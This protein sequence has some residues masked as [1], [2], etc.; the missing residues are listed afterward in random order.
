M[1]EQ[2][3]EIVERQLR[4]GKLLLAELESAIGV[5]EEAV[6][7]VPSSLFEEMERLQE[8]LARCGRGGSVIAVNWVRG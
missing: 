8:A 3:W 7:D 4:A 2:P 6:V 1:G 5:G